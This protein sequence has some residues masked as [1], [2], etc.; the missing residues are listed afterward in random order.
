MAGNG[1]RV[2][3]WR[4]RLLTASHGSRSALPGST[5]EAVFPGIS[6]ADDLD[7]SRRRNW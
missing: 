3:R 1:R 5:L 2:T 6:W 4:E 7:W